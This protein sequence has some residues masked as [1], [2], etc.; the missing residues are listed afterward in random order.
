MAQVI[1]YHTTKPEKKGSSHRNVY[2]DRDECPDGSRIKQENLV[3]GTGER[4]QCD[5]CKDH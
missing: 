4:P 5:W 1:P 2:H 3:M